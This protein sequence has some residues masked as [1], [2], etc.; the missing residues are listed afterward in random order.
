MVGSLYR[1]Q[2]WPHD[3]K[4]PL[5]LH[6]LRGDQLAYLPA[7]DYPIISMN[8]ILI[9]VRDR[10]LSLDVDWSEHVPQPTHEIIGECEVVRETEMFVFVV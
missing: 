10:C 9:L 5:V 8:P 2:R 4:H 3:S 1:P 7:I 6:R